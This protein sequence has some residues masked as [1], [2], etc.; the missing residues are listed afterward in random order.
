MKSVVTSTATEVVIV[1][2][3]VDQVS[4]SIR[5]SVEFTAELLAKLERDGIA[6]ETDGHWRLTDDAEASFG[7]AFREMSR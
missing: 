7:R 1:G 6:E 4:R 2:R 5:R 3:T